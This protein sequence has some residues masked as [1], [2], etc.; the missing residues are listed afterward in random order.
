MMVMG[1]MVMTTVMQT[2]GRGLI[3]KNK[4]CKHA[5]AIFPA[6]AS[7]DSGTPLRDSTSF[8]LRVGGVSELRMT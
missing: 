1:I 3:L 5:M 7:R 8:N 2:R 6:R 4:Q